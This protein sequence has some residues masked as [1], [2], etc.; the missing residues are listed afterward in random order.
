M[1]PSR[2]RPDTPLAFLW[3]LA[4]FFGALFSPVGDYYNGLLIRCN[5]ILSFPIDSLLYSNNTRNT[6]YVIVGNAHMVFVLTNRLMSN[7]W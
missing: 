4:R 2:Q 5:F 7:G 1:S 6:S 3:T